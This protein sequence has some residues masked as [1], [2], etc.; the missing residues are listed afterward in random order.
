MANAQRVGRTFDLSNKCVPHNADIERAILGSVLLNSDC[1][2][3]VE[4]LVLDSDF[5]V[6]IHR[7]I[8]G[9]MRKIVAAGQPVELLTVCDALNADPDLAVAG[10]PAYLASLP[11]GLHQKAPVDH[12]AR[13][14]RNDAVLRSLAYAGEFLMQSA[15]EPGAQADEVVTHLESLTRIYTDARPSKRLLLAL[16]AEELLARE[17]KPRE[18]LLKPIL[19]EQGLAM[20]YA[21]RGIGKTYIALGIAAAVSAGGTFL[22]WTAPRPRKVLYV[23]GEL[24]AS[25]L[26]QRVNMILAGL[27]GEEPESNAFQLVTPD[28]Q[29]CPMPDLATLAGQRL[30]EPLTTDVDLIILDNL[31]A[32]CRSGS[33]NDGEDWAPVQE[34][35]LRLRR[36]GKS[37]LLVHHAGKNKAQRG[38]SKRE[39][40]LDTVITLKHPSDY[41]ASE[42]LRCEV[43]FEKTRSMLGQDAK[44]FEVSLET[45][46][47]GRA[48][49][50]CRDL[51]NIKAQKAAELFSNKMSVRDVA[52]ELGISKS[53]AQRLRA[54]WKASQSEEVSQRPASTVAGPWDK[55]PE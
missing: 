49:W 31:S 27:E 32:L 5:F 38:T 52:E 40:L 25:T 37:V 12:W 39:D 51:E 55:E 42:G 41:N 11:D 2:K 33:E 20:L 43:H 28:L 46:P 14:I 7:K 54:K 16:A 36:Q 17:I 29:S 18:M 8:F 47:D 10:G 21:Y 45:G 13:I 26:Q 22:R 30:L 23:D 34:W 35:T 44:P 3:I 9:T 24:P 15:L 6:P 1:L 48:L 19:P 50:V 4:S 53:T